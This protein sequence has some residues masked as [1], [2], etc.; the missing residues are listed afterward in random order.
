M[1][2]LFS[3]NPVSRSPGPFRVALVTLG[4]LCAA[5]CTGCQSDMEYAVVVPENPDSGM[6]IAVNAFRTLIEHVTSRPV[7]VISGT[8]TTPLPEGTFLFSLGPNAVT[9]AVIP[10][11]ERQAL[12]DNGYVIRTGSFLGQQVMAGA[13]K[14]LRRDGDPDRLGNQ[15]AVYEILRRL[16]FEFFHPK[17]LHLPASIAPLTA[18]FDQTFEPDYEM[19]G[20]HV[21]TMHPVPYMFTLLDVKDYPGS[22]AI[23]NLAEARSYI[24]WLVANR[25]NYFQWCLLDT[26]DVE[27]WLD[28][29]RRVV[30]Y[31]HSRGIRVGIDAPLQFIQQNAYALAPV[32]FLPWKPQVN[33]NLELLMQVDWDYLNVEM[34]TAEAIPVSDTQTVEMLDYVASRLWDDYDRTR[35]TVKIH[36]TTG[37]KAP[38]YGNINFNFIPQFCNPHVGILPHTVQFYDL[39]GPAPTYGNENFHD[40]RDFMLEQAALGEREVFYYP[41]TAYWITFDNSVPLFLPEYVY[42]RW[43]DLNRLRETGVDGQVNFHTGWE[44]GYWLN[45]WAA[46]SFAFDAASPWES[47]IRK[48]TAIFGAAAPAVQALLED[49]IRDQV[50][51]LRDGNL[52]AYLIGHNAATDFGDRVAHTFFMPQR[53]DFRDIWQMSAED[54]L[55]FEAATIPTLRELASSCEMF[56]ARAEAIEPSV[57]AG[58]RQWYD[59]IL[60]GMRV[61][62]LRAQMVRRLYEGT[63]L[64]RKLELGLSANG[65]EE[66]S[67]LFQEARSITDRARAVVACQQAL[68][69]W[70]VE[71]LSGGGFRNPSA[72]S[73]G[74]LYT[75]ADLFYWEREMAQAIHH[76]DCVCLM[77]IDEMIEGIFGAGFVNDLFQA[78]P[79]RVLG[80]CL[81]QC[82][83]PQ[84]P[85]IVP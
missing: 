61:T 60:N 44:W 46:A 54:L 10:V 77:N 66:A 5:L 19:R 27:A 41:E 56:S 34:G 20:M 30:A 7:A 32:F 67:A 36:C 72:Y 62:A 24:D 2:K 22:E 16:G 33:R 31:A 37:Q 47:Q 39:Y 81:N 65:E 29:A 28:Y 25:Q 68:Y 15:Y 79:A 52:I 3:R 57:P 74:Y 85:P 45:N 43:A 78:I 35:L 70:P 76:A 84:F 63:V 6:Q 69:R 18:H 58:V 1:K 50:T 23:D 73:Y 48:F 42:A 14:D 71:L 40:L 82:V 13:G 11:D 21:H 26:I 8:I 9:D 80:P 51:R 64:R 12:A 49:L 59:E 4:I 53:V 55:A 75:T 83:H 38:H 17:Q